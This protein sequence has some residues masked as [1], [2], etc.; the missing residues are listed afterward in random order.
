LL[1]ALVNRVGR[2]EVAD[3]VR[4]LNNVIRGLASLD[5]TLVPA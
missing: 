3:P 2:I 5:V 4:R 1:Q